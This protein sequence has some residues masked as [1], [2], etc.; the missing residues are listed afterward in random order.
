MNETD[1]KRLLQKYQSEE[2]PNLDLK[3][4][5]NL[6]TK[7]EKVELSKDVAAMCNL[8]N[9]GYILYGF[10]NDSTPVGI[11]PSTFDDKQ[12]AQIISNRCLLPS[13]GII[14]E[15]IS[16]KNQIRIKLE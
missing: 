9:G 5:I 13:P 10:E 11:V 14:A 12:I 4:E 8:P 2:K 1:L 3:R 16:K 15:I 7:K 6:S